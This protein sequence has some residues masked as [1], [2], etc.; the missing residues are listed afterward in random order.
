MS[1]LRLARHAPRLAA[2]RQRQV[3]RHC[4][5][6]S[7]SSNPVVGSRSCASP[8]SR[9][10]SPWLISL[11]TRGKVLEA[12]EIGR[13]SFMSGRL[14]RADEDRLA[15]VGRARQLEQAAELA[16]ADDMHRQDAN[17]AGSPSPA[18]AKIDRRAPA[19]LRGGGQQRRQPPAARENGY[20]PAARLRCHVRYLQVSA[21]RDRG[22]Q[23]ARSPPWRMNATIFST[24]SSPENS[25]STS[26]RRSFSVPSGPN[27]VR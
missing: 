19:R 27:S 22:V 11:S 5:A 14:A 6:D 9:P 17:A 8:S 15:A 16:P 2:L 26:A 3:R 24:F 12:A 10:W 25:S 21:L 23:M 20:R 4:R 1:R 7:T 18:M 13:M